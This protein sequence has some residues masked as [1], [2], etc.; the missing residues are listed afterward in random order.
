MSSSRSRWL[1]LFASSALLCLMAAPAEGIVS[2]D[3]QMTA[4][5]DPAHPGEGLTYEITV[6][7]TSADPNERADVLIQSFVPESTSLEPNSPSDGGTVEGNQVNWSIDNLPGAGGQ[8]TVTLRLRVDF[9]APGLDSIFNVVIASANGVMVQDSAV[10]MI[11]PLALDLSVV[12][13]GPQ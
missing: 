13:P 12:S 11:L 8:R 5:P 2:L 7:N 9:P 10:T 1:V 6:T 3:V 4:S